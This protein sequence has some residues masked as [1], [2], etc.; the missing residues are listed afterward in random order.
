MKVQTMIMTGT[1]ALMLAGLT[2]WA[3]G[4]FDDPITT[5]PIDPSKAHSDRTDPFGLFFRKERS[6]ACEA[7][8]MVADQI[9]LLRAKEKDLRSRLCDAEARVE[10]LLV[11]LK[12][13]GEEIGQAEASLKTVNRGRLIIMGSGAVDAERDPQNR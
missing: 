4:P 9:F 13:T 2:V 11:E 10:A 5:S 6:E 3:K 12:K 1:S 8:Y 7:R